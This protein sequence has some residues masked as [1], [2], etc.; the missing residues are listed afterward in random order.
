MIIDDKSLRV[1][2]T[3]NKLI[4]ILIEM[5]T[6]KDIDYSKE[7]IQND[8]D[9]S[10]NK[11]LIELEHLYERIHNEKYF[12]SRFERVEFTLNNKLSR[13]YDNLD[14]LKDLVVNKKL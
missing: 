8:M 14:I 1:A 13:I 7:S 6:R 12:D 11:V 2:T 10:F 3:H 9:E 4:E 5:T